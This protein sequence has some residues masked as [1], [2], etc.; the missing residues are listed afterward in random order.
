MRPYYN[1]IQLH[2]LKLIDIF[3]CEVHKHMK[4]IH[5]YGRKKDL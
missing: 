1:N 5:I 2:N 3:C 4:D